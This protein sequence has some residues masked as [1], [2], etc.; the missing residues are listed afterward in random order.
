ML[1]QISYISNDEN[2]DP[3]ERKITSIKGAPFYQSS[4]KYSTHPGTWFPF[5]GIQNEDIGFYKKGTFIKPGSPLMDGHFSVLL[6]KHFPNNPYNAAM[7]HQR[8]GSVEA[9]MISSWLGGGLWESVQGKII[10]AALEEKFPHCYE[11]WPKPKFAQADARFTK[12]QNGEVNLWLCQRAGLNQISEFGYNLLKNAVAALLL[13][14]PK[15]LV[16]NYQ[17]NRSHLG[18]KTNQKG[19]RR[20]ARLMR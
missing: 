11:K 15:P 7:L 8:F 14:Q 4:G 16:F 10:K 17:T 20:S 19:E 5:F 9:L 3:V 2:G 12:Q 1:N 18:S 13:L 6:A